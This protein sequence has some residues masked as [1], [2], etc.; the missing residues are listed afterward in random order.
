MH[1]HRKDPEQNQ[2]AAEMQHRLSS[3]E[4]HTTATEETRRPGERDSDD[5]GGR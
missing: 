1:S 3:F 5:G 2:V 4:S